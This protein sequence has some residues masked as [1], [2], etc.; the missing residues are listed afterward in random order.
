MSFQ[1]MAW[2]VKQTLPARDK[3]VLLMLANYASNEAGDC[4]P[5]LETLCN[6]C[7]MS[8][9]TLKLALA[10]LEQARLLSIQHRKVETVNLSNVYRLNMQPEGVGRN[11]TEG[12]GRI[13]AEGGSNPDRG[14]GRIPTP[15]QLVKPIKETVNQKPRANA[16]DWLP[17]AEWNAFVEMRNRMRKPMTERAKE[18]AIA[19]LAKLRDAG[20]DPV[21]VL[22]QSV[23]NSWL[24]LFALKN[25]ARGSTAFAD[26]IRRSADDFAMNGGAA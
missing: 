18:L 7:G 25:G 24:G 11:P 8:R 10:S 13:P 22:N 16:P 17:P 21:A 2:A 4:Y 15:N 12:V 26:R 20:H 19:E 3:L 9:S 14:V 5:S 23:M 6:D 1:A